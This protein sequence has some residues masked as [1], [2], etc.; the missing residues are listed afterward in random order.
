MKGVVIFFK[1]ISLF[2][3]PVRDLRF[4]EASLYCFL[5][6][7]GGIVKKEVEKKRKKKESKER[8]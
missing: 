5:E 1:Q 6:F 3:A 4:L 7:T 8:T 2:C